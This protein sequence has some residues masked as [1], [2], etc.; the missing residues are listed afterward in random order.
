MLFWV[1]AQKV[2]TSAR[3]GDGSKILLAIFKTFSW[4]EEVKNQPTLLSNQCKEHQHFTVAK[5]ELLLL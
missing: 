2:L 3:E 4:W 5:P 1:W